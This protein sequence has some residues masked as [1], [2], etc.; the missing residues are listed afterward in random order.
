MDTFC[1]LGPA[2]VTP[3]ELPE[4]PHQLTLSSEINGVVKQNSNT[5]KIIHRIDYIVSYLSQ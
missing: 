3:S 2:V 1:P 5:D 4:G